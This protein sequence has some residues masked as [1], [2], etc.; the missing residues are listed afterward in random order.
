MSAQRSIAL[1]TSYEV[2]L[3]LVVVAV[4]ALAKSF[5]MSTI[6]G[7]QQHYW[8]AF[9]MPIGFIVFFVVLLAELEKSP[10]DLR[11]A[12]SELIAGWLVRRVCAVL[13]SCTDA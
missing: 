10:F 1:L 5:N 3:I 13:R 7:M 8:F 2:P 11:E 12:D 6:V 4:A 9:L